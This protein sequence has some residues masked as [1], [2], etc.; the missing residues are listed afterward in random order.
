VKNIINAARDAHRQRAEHLRKRAA[1]LSATDPQRTELE[2]EAERADARARTVRTA[3]E[4]KRDRSTALAS[5]TQ[6]C[7]TRCREG[8]ATDAHS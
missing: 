1:T 7:S 5:C 6:A 8:V 3:R 4:R 2:R